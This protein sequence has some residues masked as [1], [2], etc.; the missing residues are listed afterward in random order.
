MNNTGGVADLIVHSRGFGECYPK[1]SSECEIEILLA[2][3]TD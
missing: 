2:N 3:A 1:T